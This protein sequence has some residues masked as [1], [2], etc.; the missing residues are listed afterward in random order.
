MSEPVARILLVYAHPAAH[1]SRIN[2]VLF[3]K[4]RVLSGVAARDLYE[5]YPDFDIDV[6]AEQRLLRE[7]HLLILQH[8]IYWYSMPA[9]LKEW[10]D[11]VL[12][13]GFAYG[14]GGKALRGKEVQHVVSS[15]G[16]P[17][18]YTAE[19]YHRYA[20]RE[21]LRPLEQTVR[22][23]GMH[24]REPLMLQG[25]STLTAEQIRTHAEH[26]GELLQDYLDTP[27]PA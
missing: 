12:T 23:C 26:Y 4:V 20:L 11:S 21:F 27:V 19:G 25:S 15:G 1:R 5:L 14:P 7:A 2:R 18:A 17:Q 3:D 13:R 22:F 24:Y 10:L 16:P 6:E 9:L 8:P